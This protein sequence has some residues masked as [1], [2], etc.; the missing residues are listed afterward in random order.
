MK[1][2]NIYKYGKV[3]KPMKKI[4]LVLF[5]FLFIPLICASLESLGTYQQGEN[6]RI[7]QVCSDA[8]SINIT[9]IDPNSNN[10]TSNVEMNNTGYGEFYYDFNSTT[11]LGR[12]DVRGVSDG[13]ENTFATYFL[14]SSSGSLV[15]GDK[16]SAYIVL[17]FFL[18]AFIGGFYY[19]TKQ[20][21]FD[22]WYNSIL[23]KYEDRNHIK[24]ILSSMGYNLMKN[25]F[26]WYYLFGL[27]VILLITDITY[28]FEV[29]SMIYLMKIILSIY[30]YGFI[31]VGVF[32]FGYLQEWIS[33][34]M[35]EIKSIDMGVN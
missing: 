3:Y 4:A 13:C 24:V 9:V 32:F 27:P 14:I 29:T 35:D 25:R 10:L 30:Y 16:I 12:Y 20:I 19:V 33:N 21:N 2:K 5:V 31:L 23:R 1:N 11:S 17:L 8:T 15:S 22:K 18:I 28:T 26:I 6:V 34:L 7:G